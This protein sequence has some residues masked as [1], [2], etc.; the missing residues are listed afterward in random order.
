MAIEP[1]RQNKAVVDLI[2]AQ[3]KQ[4]VAQEASLGIITAGMEH[5]Y[6]QLSDACAKSR[7]HNCTILCDLIGNLSAKVH[8]LEQKARL[9]ISVTEKNDHK[10]D[11]MET[12]LAGLSSDMQSNMQH[13]SAECAKAR[14]NNCTVLNKRTDD[15]S[16]TVNELKSGLDASITAKAV[17]VMEERFTGL[18]ALIF[19]N[20][21]NDL[22]KTVHDR[23][24]ARYLET[25][26]YRV[27][28]VK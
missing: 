27:R 24:S 26:S 16:A 21:T 4:I 5:N 13:L 9:N 2:A 28:A 8:E 15:L 25:P 20:R 18:S 19:N 7:K 6:Q 3:S 14:V 10:L 11:V 17:D 12:R 23:S 1:L 22:S